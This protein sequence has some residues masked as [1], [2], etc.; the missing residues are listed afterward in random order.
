[1]VPP[2]SWTQV[3]YAD[4]S[5]KTGRA[6]LGYGL[7]DEA[8]VVSWG[9]NANDRYVT[10]W[11][12]KLFVVEDVSAI[13]HLAV[14]L[15]RDDGAVVYLNGTELYRENMPAGAVTAT[16][17]ALADVLPNEESTFFRRLT[18]GIPHAGTNVI[19]AAVHHFPT[20][21][22]DLSFDL[23]L[24][25][26]SDSSD[27]LRP[28]LTGQ[29]TGSVLSLNWPDGFSGWAVQETA[30]PGTNWVP[31]SAP[32]SVANGLFRV[33][34]PSTNAARFYELRKPGFCP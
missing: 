19:A 25:G 8:T 23:E 15:R 17:T 7:G 21:S 12:R 4:D 14:R 20:N 1:V 28:S 5:W 6:K 26:S 27:A 16:T 32:V 33:F 30:D 11:F 22:T 34:V 13:D 10:T 29:N 31:L 3:D 9:S 2:A 18:S 24:I